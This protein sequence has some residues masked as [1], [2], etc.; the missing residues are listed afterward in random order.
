[1]K[2]YRSKKAWRALLAFSLIAVLSLAVVSPALA[3]E[4]ITDG[5]HV[6]VEEDEV[7][8]DDL[9]ISG[10]IVEVYGT[11]KGDLFA[12]GEQ[13]IVRGVVEGN[14]FASGAIVI[15]GGEVQGAAHVAGYAIFIEPDAV[16]E[17]NVY[18]GSYSFSAQEG[19]L[20][21]R[22]LYGGGY[23]FLLDGQIDRD[24][25]VSGGAVALN[26]EIAGDALIEV[27]VQ[28]GGPPPLDFSPHWMQ[29]PLPSGFAIP[30]IP[31]GAQVSEDNV[32]GELYLNVVEYQ[33]SPEFDG[34]SP[35]VVLLNSLRK[36]AGELIALLLVGGLMAFYIYDWMEKAMSEVRENLLASLGWGVLVFFLYIP[37]VL[38]LL[39]LIILVILLL[40]MLTLGQLTGT[41][42]S[43]GALGFFAFTTAF[44]IMA[45][46]VAKV[47][48]SYLVGYELLKRVTPATLEGRW[49]KFWVLLTGVVL[50]ALLQLIP[51]GSWF[52]A[53]LV[54][55][56]GVGAIFSMYWKRYQ[57]TRT[58][59]A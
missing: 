46:L 49:G 55:V 22:S 44:G 43:V 11:V 14:L 27:G 5:Y 48:V 30:V 51:I 19:S 42:I 7:I 1:M 12:A 23:Q 25:T 21:G 33:A 20:I 50:Y 38:V 2:F 6:I 47:L 17:R 29:E 34:P 13:V 56:I 36:H 28:V 59:A 32:E 39:F 57:A 16:I 52:I 40:S 35:E 45:G 3:G 15:V 37:V 58:A 8:E 24:V 54:I 31:P 41:A 9:F 4:Y 26:G 10:Q 18:T 53:A